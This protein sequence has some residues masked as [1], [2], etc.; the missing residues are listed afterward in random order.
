MNDS[1]M[2]WK[3]EVLVQFKPYKS[4]SASESD[5]SPLLCHLMLIIKQQTLTWH[6]IR[7]YFNR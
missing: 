3:L 5:L 4:P 2:R 1:D 7:C 6:L